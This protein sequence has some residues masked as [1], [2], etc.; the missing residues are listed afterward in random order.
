[1]KYTR[2]TISGDLNGDPRGVEQEVVVDRFAIDHV[3][4]IG[5]DAVAPSG[6]GVGVGAALDAVDSRLTQR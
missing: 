3:G 5:R 2:V 4:G 6:R 1:M